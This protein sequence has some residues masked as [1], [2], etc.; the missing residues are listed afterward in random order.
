[1]SGIHLRDVI[2]ECPS[3][4]PLQRAESFDGLRF[5]FEMKGEHECG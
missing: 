4:S 1:M 5:P 2:C 3:G